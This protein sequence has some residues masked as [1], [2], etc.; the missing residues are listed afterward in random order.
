MVDKSGTGANGTAVFLL[1]KRK[2]F[3]V[4]DLVCQGIL[5]VPVSFRVRETARGFVMEPDVRPFPDPTW[6]GWPI[7]VSNFLTS[8]SKEKRRDARHRLGSQ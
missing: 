3:P 6:A 1:A 5:E 8:I 4:E 2:L 7:R